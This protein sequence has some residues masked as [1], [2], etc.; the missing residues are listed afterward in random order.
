MVHDGQHVSHARDA[1][2]TAP[3]LSSLGAGELRGEEYPSAMDPV[4][5]DAYLRDPLG[6]WTRGDAFAHFCLKEPA[7][8]GSILWGYLHATELAKALRCAEA[9]VAAFQRPHAVLV[10]ARRIRWVETTCFGL[11]ADYV[12]REHARLGQCVVHFAGV[13]PESLLPR[14][15]AEG[16]F[17]VMSAPYPFT[18][19]D[20]REEALAILERSEL[21]GTIQAIEEAIHEASTQSLLTALHEAIEREIMEPTLERAAAVLALSSRT[22]QRRLREAGTSFKRE[23]TIAR[24]QYA[25]RA[26]VDTDES[27]ARIAVDAGFGTPSAFSRAFVKIEGVRPSEWRSAHRRGS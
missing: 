2:V 19:H 14:A 6:K 3:Q 16:A 23:V 20:T 22:L 17:A 5:L 12:R 18:L 13:R 7:L 10:D 15:V 24:V 11:A 27:L 21:A 4:P 25:K 26:M 9:A 8:V 1:A